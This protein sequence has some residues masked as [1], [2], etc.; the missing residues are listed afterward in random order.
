M[1]VLCYCDRNVYRIFRDKTSQLSPPPRICHLDCDELLANHVGTF[2][3]PLPTRYPPFLALSSR[4]NTLRCPVPLLSPYS[5]GHYYRSITDLMS[6]SPHSALTTSSSWCRDHATPNFAL[7]FLLVIGPF[8]LS[9][10]I[11]AI[12]LHLVPVHAFK[13]FFAVYTTRYHSGL[14]SVTISK[15]GRTR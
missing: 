15:T 8:L 6:T 14:P 5:T 3:I 13:T 7:F 11:G 9:S 1:V 12:H 10:S 4:R 2:D